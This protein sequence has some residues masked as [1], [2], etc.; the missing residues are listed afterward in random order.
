MIAETIALT[1]M[2]LVSIL[3]L[4]LTGVLGLAALTMIGDAVE[5]RWH[6]DALARFAT[7]A[8]L[9]VTVCTILAAGIVWLTHS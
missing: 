3:V 7:G 9:L 5:R 2:L 1:G 6:S 8:I 4:A